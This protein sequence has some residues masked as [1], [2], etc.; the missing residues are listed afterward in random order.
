MGGEALHPPNSPLLFEVPVCW[1]T[2]ASYPCMLHI[3][4]ILLCMVNLSLR[5]IL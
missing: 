4:T 5:T 1:S 2:P 3:H